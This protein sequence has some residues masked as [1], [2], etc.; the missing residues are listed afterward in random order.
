MSEL[1]NRI[2]ALNEENTC[3]RREM[4]AVSQRHRATLTDLQ[5]LA[6]RESASRLEH[7]KLQMTLT[8]DLGLLKSRLR[9]VEREKQALQERLNKM[10]AAQ[11]VR[12]TSA[13]QPPPESQLVEELRRQLSALQAGARAAKRVGGAEER[14]TADLQSR[15]ALSEKKN[16]QLE[17]AVRALE[18]SAPGPPEP[19]SPELRREVYDL[20]RKVFFLESEKQHLSDRVEQLQSHLKVARDMRDRSMTDRVQVLPGHAP[21]GGASRLHVGGASRLHVCV[22]HVRVVW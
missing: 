13:F 10:A 18:A 17:E 12:Q 1:T 7:V 11:E 8:T 14:E 2:G 15:L 4:E 5:R 20:Q 6:E 16:K 19:A 22:V 21:M 9:Q 3:L